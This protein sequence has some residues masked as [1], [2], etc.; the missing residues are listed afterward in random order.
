MFP[1]G[2]DFVCD[3]WK[4]LANRTFFFLKIGML[5]LME[6]LLQEC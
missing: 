5:S 4:L 1:S 3:G 6:P 2:P